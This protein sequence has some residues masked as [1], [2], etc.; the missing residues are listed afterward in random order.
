MAGRA[1]FISESLTAPT[2]LGGGGPTELRV[3]GRAA[4]GLEVPIL[5]LSRV[6]AKELCLLLA[7]IK[8]LV[9]RQ[10]DTGLA[11]RG[12]ER[13][14]VEAPEEIAALRFSIDLDFADSSDTQGVVNL[15]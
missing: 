3:G 12:A 2:A 8:S 9:P 5:A 13:G 1:F 4:A 14:L 6:R 15:L 10:V 7:A 11:G